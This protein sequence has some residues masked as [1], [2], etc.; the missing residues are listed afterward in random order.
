MFHWPAMA[1]VDK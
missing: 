1:G